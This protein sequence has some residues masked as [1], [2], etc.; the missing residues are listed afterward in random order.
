MFVARGSPLSC[1]VVVCHGN[2]W[3]EGIVRS[4]SGASI[5]AAG[6]RDALQCSFALLFYNTMHGLG[7]TTMLMGCAIMFIFQLALPHS[8]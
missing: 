2:W 8:A 1:F 3:S 7:R 6:R 4:Q 5:L